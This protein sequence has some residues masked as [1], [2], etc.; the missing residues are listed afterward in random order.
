MKRKIKIFSIKDGVIESVIESYI[1]DNGESGLIISEQKVNS[2]GK[3]AEIL[4][5]KIVKLHERYLSGDLCRDFF[6]EIRCK[7]RGALWLIE[8][9][10]AEDDH[11]GGGAA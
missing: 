7:N 3:E 9:N 6:R 11:G 8:N 10:F 4:K 5:L 1:P 2:R